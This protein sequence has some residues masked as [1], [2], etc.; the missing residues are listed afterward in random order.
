MTLDATAGGLAPPARRALTM[1]WYAT[2][3]D[4]GAAIGPLVGYL[5][6]VGVG[7]E[8]MYR[9]VAGLLVLVGLAYAVAFRPEVGITEQAA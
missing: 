8:W 2:C 6:G 3:L 9:G 1:S 7:L 4:L 5:V